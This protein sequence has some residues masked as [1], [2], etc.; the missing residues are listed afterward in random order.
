MNRRPTAVLP[1]AFLGLAL[2]AALP[3]S[4]QVLKCLG[5]DGS[6]A[7]V[8]GT[9]CPGDGLP[10]A[11]KP[12]HEASAPASEAVPPA[13]VPAGGVV[14]AP[15]PLVE[16]GV[17]AITQYAGRFGWL[18]ADTLA[19]TTYSDPPA[20]APWMVRRVVAFD[21]PRRTATTLVQRGFLD[22]TD[23]AHGL[24]SLEIGDLESRFGIG[25]TGQS[26]AGRFD[27][28]NPSTHALEPTPAGAFAGW[29]PHACVK[30]APDD[31]AVADLALSK[32]PMR[33]LEPEHGVIEWGLG[34]DGHPMPPTLQGAKHHAVLP[35]SINDISHDV[36]WLPFAKAYQLAAGTPETPLVTMDPE[37]RVTRR[38]VPAALVHSLEAAGATG[39]GRLIAV[40]DGA[41]YVQPGAARN[42]G[43][44]YLV[45]GEQSRR[46]WCT[47][48]PA[49]G[50]AQ[51]DDACTMSQPPQV[52]PDGCSVAFDAKPAKPARAFAGDPTFKVIE[53][54]TPVQKGKTLRLS[55]AR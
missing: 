8:Q 36:R 44:L 39:R 4:A 14:D 46:V 1:G 2:V 48:T 49:A 26:P 28:W 33:Y 13:H 27:A 42:G 41:L 45:Q 19:L 12:R 47:A 24:V 18:D 17:P 21:L 32:K 31:L 34:A 16:T 23:P 38:A 54:C 55:L 20:K 29:H 53:L 10:M 30:T 25:G 35:L 15:L 43:G 7:Y 5:A 22:C 40:R 9:S 52:A 3:A 11:Q 6:V 37:G 51:G 50:Q